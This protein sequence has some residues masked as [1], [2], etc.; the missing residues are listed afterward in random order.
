M[1]DDLFVMI[2]Y[3][4]NSASAQNALPGE[5][6]RDSIV[7]DT[8]SKVAASTSDRA[9]PDVLHNLERYVAICYHQSFPGT[10]IQRKYFSRDYLHRAHIAVDIGLRLTAIARQT[11]D[12]AM[13]SSTRAGSSFDPN[14][15]LLMAATIVQHN[16]S[17][18]VVRISSVST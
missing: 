16:K 10:L 7:R 9:I 2:R 5:C 3:V 8:L 13:P 4:V 15:L 6:L 17:Q 14:S 18:S 1:S 12:A 11:A